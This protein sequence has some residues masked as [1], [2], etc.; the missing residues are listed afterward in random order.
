MQQH[1]SLQKSVFAEMV[2]KGVKPKMAFGVSG[3]V[4]SDD[5]G[6][7]HLRIGLAPLRPGMRH[8]VTTA[9]STAVLL[10]SSYAPAQ[11]EP[12]I[13][14]R[15]SQY[16]SQKTKRYLII[17][18]S[19]PN[20][21][22]FPPIPFVDEDAKQMKA[23]LEALNYHPLQD[24]LAGAEVNSANVESA[25]DSIHQGH[26]EKEVILVYFS[27]HGIF[28]PEDQDVLLVLND[29][30]K[31]HFTDWVRMARGGSRPD[32]P[33]YR[34]Q[35]VFI[36]DACDSGNA[37]W[38]T[39]LT[40]AELQLPTIIMASSTV[41]QKSL[42][43][44]DSNVS[45]YSSVLR[46]AI[47][48]D[49]DAA[50]DNKDG[51][52]EYR[53]LKQYSAR[54]LRSLYLKHKIPNEMH[55]EGNT[56]LPL[57]IHY[58]PAKDKSPDSNEHFIVEGEELIPDSVSDVATVV[59]V[60]EGVAVPPSVPADLTAVAAGIPNRADLP[61]LVLGYKALAEKRFG[62][63]VAHFQNSK[64]SHQG[65]P[66]DLAAAD[67]GIARA[68]MFAGEFSNASVYYESARAYY[69]NESA[70]VLAE[71]GVNSAL[72]GDLGRGGA[73]LTYANWTLDKHYESPKAGS[74]V[75]GVLSFPF[76]LVTRTAPRQAP[77]ADSP[78]SL[79]IS[80]SL[81]LVL[82]KGTD[83]L[84]ADKEAQ[85]SISI[86]TALSKSEVPGN[87]RAA[88]LALANIAEVK[89]DSGDDKSALPLYRRADE[90]FQSIGDTSLEYVTMLSSYVKA[91]KDSN[92]PGLA[93]ATAIKS[94][95]VQSQ[96]K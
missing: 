68:K 45:A 21:A 88:A 87:R 6:P 7:A 89:K 50:D 94:E 70:G 95:Q 80:Q 72:A 38:R 43:V 2:N 76:R 23:F 26:S 42:Q 22:D 52:L 74:P 90:L 30:S 17:S 18:A 85:R 44:L 65:S 71:A 64:R 93:A 41:D 59:S 77:E 47:T 86:S 36:L 73:Y 48:T 34:G 58:D 12:A 79:R 84:A 69:G 11:A 16:W 19:N 49:W 33:S 15:I 62:N 75:L 78:D 35:L 28:G 5:R 40:P 25:L 1:K 20:R 37:V 92:K 53:E 61:D 81:A 8:L 55:P 31:M 57:F 60:R 24:P 51:F 91:L 10:L 83:K 9:C 29:G 39:A 13:A 82:A 66:S 27:G 46:Q 4:N 96:T 56:D 67:L 32:Q 63:A 3:K 54:A 14:Q